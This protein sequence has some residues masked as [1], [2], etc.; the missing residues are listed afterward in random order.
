MTEGVE[1]LSDIDAL[2]HWLRLLVKLVEAEKERRDL[3]DSS[4]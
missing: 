2:L 4:E 1:Y 3:E